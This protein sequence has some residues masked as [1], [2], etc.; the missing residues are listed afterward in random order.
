MYNYKLVG[1]LSLFLVSGIAS[2]MPTL[3]F[4][5]D[6]PGSSVSTTTTGGFGSMTTTLVAGL[7]ATTFSLAAGQSQSFDFFDVSVNLP[8]SGIGSI[9]AI[10]AFDTPTSAVVGA[11]GSAF[12]NIVS[13]FGSLQGGVIVWDSSLPVTINLLDGSSFLVDFQDILVFSAQFTVQATVT[14]LKVATPTGIPEPA[15]P[16]LLAI[17]LVGLRLILKKHCEPNT[18]VA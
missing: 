16:L 18:A 3:N 13:I 8:S 1:L 6:G 12:A 4:D 14:A 7:D 11:G 2:A 10:L 5:I 15:A 17:G 9:A